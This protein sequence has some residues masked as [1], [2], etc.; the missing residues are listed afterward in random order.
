MQFSASRPVL[1]GGKD[2]RRLIALVKGEINNSVVVPTIVNLHGYVPRE[3]ERWIPVFVFLS[4]VTL[5][6]ESVR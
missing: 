2:K 1:K 6:F 4:G 3:E 5:S